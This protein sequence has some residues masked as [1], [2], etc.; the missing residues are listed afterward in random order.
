MKVC[1]LLTCLSN[2]TQRVVAEAEPITADLHQRQ[3]L[4]D[5]Y[6]ISAE[7]FEQLRDL[8]VMIDGSSCPLV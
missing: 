6:V 2:I 1:I 4:A 8:E 3:P 7:L 5:E